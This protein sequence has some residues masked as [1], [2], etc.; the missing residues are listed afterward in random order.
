M[1]LLNRGIPAAGTKIYWHE[2][3]DAIRQ[4]FSDFDLRINLEACLK[5]LISYHQ[6]VL[7][8]SGRTALFLL[9]KYL[10][11]TSNR[12]IVL[13]PAYT[14]P[15]VGYAVK[16]AGLTLGIFDINPD[17]ISPHIDAIRDLLSD[18][19]LAIIPAH[20][21]GLVHNL[22]KIREMSKRHSIPIID[23]S[24]QAFPFTK[25]INQNNFDFTILSF[26]TGKSLGVG[27]GGAVI[28]DPLQYPDFE[29]FAAKALCPVSRTRGMLLTCKQ[30]IFN[31]AARKTIYPFLESISD[32]SSQR[33]DFNHIGLERMNDNAIHLLIT[34]LARIQKIRT[35][36]INNANTILQQLE[37]VDEVR[38]PLTQFHEQLGIS[39]RLPLIFNHPEIRN[40]VKDTLKKRGLGVGSLYSK[41]LPT[42]FTEKDLL[43]PGENFPGAEYICSHLLT[44]PIH[45]FILDKDMYEI[46]NVIKEKISDE[47]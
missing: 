22:E 20:I 32:H 43:S 39:P 38:S 47:Q 14:C 6:F 41:T 23:D 45:E 2:F 17:D 24:A 5:P 4:S 13:V 11:K 36:R 21:C 44:L 26:D 46:I 28:F 19:V 34:L 27:S 25:Q 1:Y 18:D 12:N 35:G 7:T 16:Q 8:G 33:N 29:R 9:L 30:L 37:N 42:H 15:S 3:I 31:L 40:T 10:S